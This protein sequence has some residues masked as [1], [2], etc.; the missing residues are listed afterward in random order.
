M[1]Q[2]LN[3]TYCTPPCL[4]VLAMRQGHPRLARG[5]CLRLRG[6]LEDK[7]ALWTLLAMRCTVLLLS[8]DLRI[9]KLA[10]RVCVVELSECENPLTKCPILFV[11]CGTLTQTKE[12][13]MIWAAVVRKKGGP[14]VVGLVYKHG[15]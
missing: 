8:I 15:S 11:G 5:N 2:F 7:R 10:Q 9:R 14:K 4:R 6:N 13:L 12:A 3:F 1:Y